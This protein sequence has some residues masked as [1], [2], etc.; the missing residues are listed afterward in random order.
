VKA[1]GAH[2]NWSINNPHELEKLVPGL[3]FDSE[4]WYWDPVEIKRHYSRLYGHF[5]PIL[6]HITPIR[7]LGRALRYHFDHPSV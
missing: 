7:R 3:I 6:F 2:L 1:S 4:S 5:M